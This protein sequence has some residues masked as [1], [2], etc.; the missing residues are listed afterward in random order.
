MH[1]VCWLQ[2]E[3]AIL[4]FP[5]QVPLSFF[6]KWLKR[7]DISLASEKADGKKAKGYPPDVVS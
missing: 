6:K 7:R 2:G 5:T 3:S 4:F 1:T